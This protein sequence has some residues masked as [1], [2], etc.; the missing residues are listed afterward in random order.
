MFAVADLP[1][2][3]AITFDE[4]GNLVIRIGDFITWVAMIFMVVMIVMAGIRFS[5]AGDSPDR[6]KKAQQSL[7]SAI[8]GAMVILGTGV[9]LQTAAGLVTREFFC[10]IS[11]FGICL[12]N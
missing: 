9:I 6:Y 5:T 3:K 4:I 7:K 11:I 2:G 8:V 1:A 10:R 12:L